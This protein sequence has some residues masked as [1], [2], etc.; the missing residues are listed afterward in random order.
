MSPEQLEQAGTI[1]FGRR[2]REDFAEHFNLDVRTVRKMLK[3]DS[4]IY[5]SLASRVRTALVRHRMIL[6]RCLAEIG[7]KQ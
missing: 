2:W 4:R 5:D 1:L 6:D 3:G 7:P